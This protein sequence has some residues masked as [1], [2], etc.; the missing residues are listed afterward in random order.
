MDLLFGPAQGSG[1]WEPASPKAPNFG[2][3]VHCESGPDKNSVEV[4]PIICIQTSLMVASLVRNTRTPMHLNHPAV[5]IK[6]LDIPTSLRSL[7]NAKAVIVAENQTC[8]LVS[9]PL[10]AP[11][12]NE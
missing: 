8:H 1:E 6:V 3:S 10:P 5:H 11:R 2:F 4:H 7:R 9:G 12:A